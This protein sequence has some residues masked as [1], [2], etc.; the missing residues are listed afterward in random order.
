VCRDAQALYRYLTTKVAAI[1]EVRSV[2]TV[3]LAT[4]LKQN[5]FLVENDYLKDPAA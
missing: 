5:Y 3:P 4:R 2:E 1:E